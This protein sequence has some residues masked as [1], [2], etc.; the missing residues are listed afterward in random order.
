[1]GRRP[2]WSSLWRAWRSTRPSNSTDLGL[3]T[4]SGEHFGTFYCSGDVLPPFQL[5]WCCFEL[6]M[7]VVKKIDNYDYVVP[8]RTNDTKGFEKYHWDPSSPHVRKN[9]QIGL[10]PNDLVHMYFVHMMT[11]LCNDRWWPWEDQIFIMAKCA[12]GLHTCSYWVTR[13]TGLTWLNYT[14]LA[15]L[16]FRCNAGKGQNRNFQKPLYK[17]KKI[18]K[19][20]C[21]R[22]QRPKSS[23]HESSS[24]TRHYCRLITYSP[25]GVEVAEQSTSF[26]PIG[27]E[28]S[29]QAKFQFLKFNPNKVYLLVSNMSNSQW[30]LRTVKPTYSRTQKNWIA[31]LGNQAHPVSPGCWY[32]DT[33]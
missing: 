4:I 10:Q 29:L 7:V 24:A 12:V 19:Q 25:V 13:L 5:I 16:T 23:N 18:K 27:S 1:M 20:I 6:S 14:W 33:G 2:P 21:H 3:R 11:K 31:F 28:I 30:T 22:Y 32:S 17:Q 9:F 15:F 8:L 26:G